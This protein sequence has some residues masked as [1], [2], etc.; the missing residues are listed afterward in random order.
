MNFCHKPSMRRKNVAHVGTHAGGSA[1]APMI[2][3]NFVDGSVRSIKLKN[4][5]HDGEDNSDFRY[6]DYGWYAA[7]DTSISDHQQ[8]AWGNKR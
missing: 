7:L 1:N 8:K 4:I 5:F 3:C 6:G 2:N